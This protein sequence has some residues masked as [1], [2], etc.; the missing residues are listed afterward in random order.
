MKISK[1]KYKYLF[2]ARKAVHTQTDSDMR[3][4]PVFSF[5][6]VYIQK[7]ILQNVLLPFLSSLSEKK[8]Q[9]PSLG[10]YLFKST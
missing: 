9:M 1:V 5:Y 2:L 3:R 10:L 7:N 8:V 6:T 4:A